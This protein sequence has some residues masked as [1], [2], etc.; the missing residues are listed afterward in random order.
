MMY[1]VFIVA[2]RIFIA[3]C[4]I[5]H[6]SHWFLVE[7]CGF[8][9]SCGA[10][11]PKCAGSVVVGYGFSNCGIQAPNSMGCLVCGTWVL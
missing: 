9:S 10:W 2:H 6:C 5:F 7:A 1:Q 3:A 4:R 8:L 11:A